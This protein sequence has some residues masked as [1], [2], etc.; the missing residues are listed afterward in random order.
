MGMFAIAE[1][2]TR[3]R[4]ERSFKNLKCGS[5]WPGRSEVTGGGWT[6]MEVA[7][8]RLPSDQRNGND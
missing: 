8:W 3:M 1:T 5:V 6:V 2:I 7:L 4:V